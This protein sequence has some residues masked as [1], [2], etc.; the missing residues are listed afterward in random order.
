MMAQDDNKVKM[1][2]LCKWNGNFRFNW[3]K[4]KKWSASKGRG[5]FLF[6]PHVLFAFEPV[7][8]VWLDGKRPQDSLVA[9]GA[10]GYS[11]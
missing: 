6:D 10:C 11:G 5:N 7:K 9:R 4:R 8:P 3:L 1:Q 2:I